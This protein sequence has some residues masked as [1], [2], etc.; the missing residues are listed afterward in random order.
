MAEL[1][2]NARVFNNYGCAEAMPRLTVRPVKEGE[3]GVGIG[4]PLPGVELEQVIIA[5]EEFSEGQVFVRFDP[6]GAASDHT[7]ILSQPKH[8]QVFTVEVLALTGLIRLHEGFYL[9][10]I[11]DDGDFD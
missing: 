10:E 3:E 9:R 8:N 1:F 2:P 5:G 4:N 6:L 11:P 7:V